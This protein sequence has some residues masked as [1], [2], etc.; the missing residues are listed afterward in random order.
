MLFFDTL[1]TPR[2]GCPYGV[3]GRK[4]PTLSGGGAGIRLQV[5]LEQDQLGNAQIADLDAEAGQDLAAHAVAAV[6]VFRWK[7]PGK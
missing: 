7:F 1:R 5:V 2:E 4:T 3:G 6:T